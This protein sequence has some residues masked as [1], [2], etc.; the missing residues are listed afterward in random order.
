[1][2]GGNLLIRTRDIRS[3]E[4][5]EIVSPS[6]LSGDLPNALLIGTV[7]IFHESSGCLQIYPAPS[8][9]DPSALPIWTMHFITDPLT[10]PKSH[11]KLTKTTSG[12]EVA[13]LCPESPLLKTLSEIFQPLEPYVTDLLVTWESWQDLPCHLPPYSSGNLHISL[14]RYKLSFSGDLECR[15][16]PG[17]SIASKQAFGTLFGLKNKLVLES[18]DGI[19]RRK[20]IVPDGTIVV[21]PTPE[22]HPEVT[23]VLPEDAGLQIKMFI[24][25][26]D[27]LIGR[28]VG[29]GV[30]TSW[31]LLTYLHVLTSSH[32]SDPLTHRTGV[33]QALTMLKSANSFAF[34]QLTTEDMEFLRLIHSLTPIRLYYPAYL[35]SMEQVFWNDAL[36]PL[37]QSELL[38]PLVEA[39]VDHGSNQA[40]FEL[41]PRKVTVEYEGD[42]ALR[43]RAELRSSRYI[44]GSEIYRTEATKSIHGECDLKSYSFSFASS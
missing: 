27:E 25:E 21:T 38:A 28:L 31:Y 20:V 3:H 32:L 12:V 2:I 29:D 18:K 37:S 26:V 9:W 14:P 41:T 17:L 4:L 10:I 15:E 35:T 42:V 22:W 40:L 11:P 1:M 13:M 44:P 5:S 7:Y 30:L 24:Y 36:S 33:Q 39:I 23:I 8:G 34:R 16:L 6:K 19:G 43:E